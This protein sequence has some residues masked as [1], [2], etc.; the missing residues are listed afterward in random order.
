MTA[1]ITK[2]QVEQ[3]SL[4][5]AA[6]VIDAT[7][8]AIQAA[9]VVKPSFLVEPVYASIF[10]SDAVFEKRNADRFVYDTSNREHSKHHG[11]ASHFIHN[12]T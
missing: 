7:S 11:S 4:E 5:L 8:V 6:G 3:I 2:V 12:E 9:V 10:Q 1:K